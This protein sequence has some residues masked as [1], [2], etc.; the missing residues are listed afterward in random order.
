[1]N[2]TVLLDRS[3]LLFDYQSILSYPSE[4]NVVLPFALLEELRNR[5]PRS[6]TAR[7]N[8]D[9]LLGVVGELSEEGDLFK[10]V[11]TDRGALFRLHRPSKES[12]NDVRHRVGQDEQDLQ[13]FATAIDLHEQ[14]PLELVTRDAIVQAKAALFNLTVSFYKK[15]SFRAE[16]LYPGY[17]THTVDHETVVAIRDKRSCTTSLALAPNEYVKIVSDEEQDLYTFCRYDSETGTLVPLSSGSSE[18]PRWVQPRNIEQSLALDALLNDSIKLVTLIGKAGTGKTLLA[19][20]AGLYKTIDGNCYDRIL[21]SRPTLPMGQDIGF[22][23]GSVEEKL[24]PWMYPIADNVDLILRQ[25]KSVRSRVQGFKDLSEMGVLLIEPLTY[26]RGRSIHNQYLIVD[27]AQNLTTHEIKTILTRAGEGTKIILAGDPYQIDNP[28][29]I[30]TTS[31][32]MQVVEKLRNEPE[33]AHIT[34][35][36]GERSRLSELAAD[37]L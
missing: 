37:L 23:P 4:T 28:D 24:T 8:C 27:E 11:I 2:R 26:I 21:V 30:S 10:G 1:M 31:G 16:E 9:E 32:L 20:A 3:T 17:T 36:Q 22:L 12:I 7:R 14:L 5:P 15:Q 25:R 19:I 29:V 35:T 34:F 18:V 6:A 33:S 13:L